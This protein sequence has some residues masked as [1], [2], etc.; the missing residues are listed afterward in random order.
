VY[1]F[2]G[3]TIGL[4]LVTRMS[5]GIRS[6]NLALVLPRWLWGGSFVLMTWLC[7]LASTLA[8]VRVRNVEPGMV[9]R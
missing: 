5:E 4:F 9:F 3:T 2:I 8:L 1:A 6:A 7:I